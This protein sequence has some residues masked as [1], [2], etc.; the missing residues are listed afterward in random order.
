MER[1]EGRDVARLSLSPG[2]QL[3]WDN[4]RL[5]ERGLSLPEYLQ[6]L[7]GTIPQHLYT[8]PSKYSASGL[9]GVP[10]PGGVV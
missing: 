1:S 5:P 6:P 10:S 3:H 4:G 9:R 2:V 7:P 8:A